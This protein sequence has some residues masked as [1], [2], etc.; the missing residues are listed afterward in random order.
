ML[1]CQKCGPTNEGQCYGP[2]ICC[3]PGIG[4]SINNEISKV[5][6]MENLSTKPCYIEGKKCGPSL[7]GVC[8]SGK[9]CCESGKFKMKIK[10]LKLFNKK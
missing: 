1:K 5:C 10:N 2:N 8:A 9:L 6:R 4:C 3:G 7:N